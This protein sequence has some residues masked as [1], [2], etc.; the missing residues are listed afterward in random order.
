MR[1]VALFGNP[2]RRL[3]SVVMHNAAFAAFDID[4]RYE[5]REV[6]EPELA[7]QVAQ[8]RDEKWLGFQ[9]TAPFKRA[10][11]PLLDEVEGTARRIGAVNSVSIAADG[12]LT[13]FNTD[14]IGFMTGVRAC[15]RADLSGARVVL[16]G[17]GGAGHAAA[18]GLA[19]AGVGRLTVLDLDAADSRRLATEFSPFAEIEPLAFHDPLAVARLG[20]ADL[21]VNA[22]S[23]GMLTPGP[24][25]DVADL[26]P[27]AA[28]FDV[29]YVPS[30]TE[31]VRRARA[32][33]MR[34]ANGVDMLVAQAAAAFVRW[35]G[36]SDPTLHMREAVDPLLHRDDLAP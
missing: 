36:E 22:T 21:F 11:M 34:A 4:A 1:T 19:E 17:S 10:I 31:L 26:A 29:V 7:A 2:L 14:V 13:G 24:V 23:V 8:A 25:I 27:E 20:E 35:T 15:V 30:E 5:L 6:T 32:R 28:V 9:I 33:G 16:A 3:H 18:Y 12:R